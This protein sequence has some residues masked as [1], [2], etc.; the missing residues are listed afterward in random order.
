MREKDFHHFFKLKNSNIQNL[1]LK[2]KSK[3]PNLIEQ[4]WI[5]LTRC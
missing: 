4:L 1:K 2:L 5:L 3:T